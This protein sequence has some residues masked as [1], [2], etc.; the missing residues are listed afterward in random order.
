MFVTHHRLD[1][2]TVKTK[3]KPETLGQIQCGVLRK[4]CGFH[5][6]IFFFSLLFLCFRS[7]PA[8]LVLCPGFACLLS[9]PCYSML[10]QHFVCFCNLSRPFF[11]CFL[12]VTSFIVHCVHFFMF[13]ILLVLLYLR[14]MSSF[15]N[16]LFWYGGALEDSEQLPAMNFKDLLERFDV[17]TGTRW[18]NRPGVSSS[19][20]NTG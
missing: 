3:T 16:A 18:S 15:Y 19:C 1:F 5:T 14:G 12:S 20:S 2:G 9:C 8:Q 10:L 7:L 17:T 13:V 6:V 11:F 4:Y